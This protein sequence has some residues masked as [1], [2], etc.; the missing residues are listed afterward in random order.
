VRTIHPWPDSAY[1]LEVVAESCVSFR[2]PTLLIMLAT[3]N[4]QCKPVIDVGR[5]GSG[6]SPVL[7]FAAQ[8]STAN[9]WMAWQESPR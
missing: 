8:R 7:G 6:L 4:D 1:P 9:E 5:E 3:E 2:L